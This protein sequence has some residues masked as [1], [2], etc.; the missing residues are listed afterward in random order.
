MTLDVGVP[1]DRPSNAAGGADFDPPRDPLLPRPGGRRLR[2]VL[3]DLL[4][5]CGPHM[6]QEHGRHAGQHLARH[7]HAVVARSPRRDLRR[8]LKATGAEAA[9]A[10]LCRG[11]ARARFSYGIRI[12]NA[13]L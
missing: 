9:A 11:P 12:W 2:G 6:E 8:S 1:G 10:L 4:A 5:R 13:T 3:G 7:T